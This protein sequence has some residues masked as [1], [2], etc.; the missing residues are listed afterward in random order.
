[1]ILNSCPNNVWNPIIRLSI[2]LIKT[3]INLTSR[4]P[5]SFVVNKGIKYD[6]S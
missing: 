1:M 6:K 3:F 5:R 4:R 2:I